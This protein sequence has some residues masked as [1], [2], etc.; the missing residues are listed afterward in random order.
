M[1]RFDDY[2]WL[3]RPYRKVGKPMKPADK[4]KIYLPFAALSG[5]GSSII[6][7]QRYREEGFSLESDRIEEINNSLV[8]LSEELSRGNHPEIN[9]LYYDRKAQLNKQMS[10]CIEEVS[11]MQFQI[12]VNSVL[13]HFDDIYELVII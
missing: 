12:K 9:I 10:G 3:V 5:F 11:D 8:M 13:I 6:E 7:T 2:I 4:A 1:G